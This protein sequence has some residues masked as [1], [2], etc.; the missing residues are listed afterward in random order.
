MWSLVSIFNLLCIRYSFLIYLL[1]YILKRRKQLQHYS[2]FALLLFIF[3]L[4]LCYPC[5]DPRPLLISSPPGSPVTQSERPDRDSQSGGL[6][7]AP[8]EQQQPVSLCFLLAFSTRRRKTG[9]VKCWCNQSVRLSVD[10]IFVFG[11]SVLKAELI[12]A[13]SWLELTSAEEDGVHPESQDRWC[14]GYRYPGQLGLSVST[15]IWWVI[16]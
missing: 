5:V 14:G 9:R 8:A 15:E 6:P 3:Y 4:C 11:V 10:V 12:G 1:K 2:D 16:S 13:A 7:A